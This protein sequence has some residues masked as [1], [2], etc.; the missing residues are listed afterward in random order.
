MTTPASDAD[1]SVV[2]DAIDQL[3]RDHLPAADRS[4]FL[5]AQFDAGLAWVHFPVGSGGLA[6]A[7]ALQH[8]VSTRLAEAGAPFPQPE[9]PHAYSMGGPTVLA[10][11][12]EEQ[13]RR[14]LRP[15]FRADE[16][17]CQL[18][19]EPGAG[20]DLAA[21]ACRA[22]RDGSDWIVNGQK[23]W[24]SGAQQSDLGMLV[25]RTDPDVPKHQGLT[26]FVI[27]MRTPGIEVR[28]LRQMTGNAEF[29]EVYLTDVRIPDACRI[30]PVGAGW[31]VSIS[32]LMNERVMFGSEGRRIQSVD[33][34]LELYRRHACPGP[35][36]RMRLI[37]LW[38]NTR[39]FDLSTARAS[40]SLAGGSP[41]PEGSISKIGFAEVNQMGY[42]L[43]L[44][45]T[46]DESLLYDDYA[47]DAS[48]QAES[49][50]AADVPRKFLR[51][52][53]NSIEGGSTEI[54]RNIL[55]ERVLGLPPEQRADKDK[56]WSQVPRS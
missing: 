46:G 3:L 52:R 36:L 47:L 41:G 9:S 56:P 22:V 54:M 45:L 19:S 55:A 24:S 1:L 5:D 23:T 42:E 14:Y 49:D 35:E 39:V 12:T 44:D 13:V 8:V 43:C 25:A 50:S 16:R 4:A 40:A 38:I 33:L 30:G 37:Q 31:K 18:F 7:R 2:H 10:W 21:V 26:F 20:S 6:V 48:P 51:S 11:G 27:D 17:W 28:P 34:A 32:T 53:A 15:A 29:S